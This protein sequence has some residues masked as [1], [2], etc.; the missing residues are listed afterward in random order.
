MRR[1]YTS[2]FA[3]FI[4]SGKLPVNV[5]YRIRNHPERR[6]HDHD[7]SELVLITEGS[8]THIADDRECELTAGD[9]LV[10]HPGTIHGYD[11]TA[12]A[13]ILNLIF[14]SNQLPMP[15]L[16]SGE[17]SLFQ[18]ILLTRLSSDNP[19]KPVV[20]LEKP[21]RQRVEA[22]I[23]EIDDEL[24]SSRPGGMF[25]CLTLIMEVFARISRVGSLSLPGERKRFM[26]G[27]SLRYM[28]LH[29]NEPITV[30]RLARISCMSERG[31]RR[32]FHNALGCSPIEYL[33]K[34]RLQHVQELLISS[35]DE[36]G[37][38]ALNCGF[39][40]SNYLAKKFKE[41]F[42]LTPGEFRARNKTT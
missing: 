31:F 33:F 11:H 41:T 26:V 40:D 3:L 27:D 12:N 36:I 9:V 17:L 42:G 21:E 35:E 14:D 8:V 38:I 6:F 30:D 25:I 18:K 32:H 10:I 24:K 4:S 16:D 39:Y 19:A 5:T 2:R 7:Y 13:G 20:H 34:I 15:Q 22:M 37:N 1:D 28:K 29:Y 23:Y